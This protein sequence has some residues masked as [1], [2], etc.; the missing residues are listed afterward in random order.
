MFLTLQCD[1]VSAACSDD[2]IADVVCNKALPLLAEIRLRAAVAA[3]AV[4]AAA[5]VGVV[6]VEVGADLQV[7]EVSAEAAMSY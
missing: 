4:A 7:E 3:V 6:G 2:L 5:G 1:F